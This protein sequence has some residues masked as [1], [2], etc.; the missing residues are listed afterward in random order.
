MEDTHK[1]DNATIEVMDSLL[2]TGE[3]AKLCGVTPDAVLKWIKKGKLPATRT[4]GGHYRVSREDCAAL[5]LIDSNG[6]QPATASSGRPDKERVPQR[7]WEYFGQRGAPP[8]TCRNC[9]V[10]Q[11]RVQYCYKLAELGEST[12][13]R[14]DFCR[15]NCLECPFYRACQGMATTVLVVTRD[16]GLT[17]RLGKQADASKVT[18]R[19][20]RSGYESATLIGTFR[21]AVV[22]MDSDLAEVRE[23]GLLESIVRDDRIPGV[24]V[25][26]AH[27]QGDEEAVRKLGVPTLT[28][29]FTAEQIE[30]LGESVA[31]GGRRASGDAT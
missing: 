25:F 10:Y 22:V 26:V 14:H 7:C 15:N 3:V 19:F 1:T 16:D 6:D 18:L 29:P 5:G 27:R 28:A 31:H 4:A 17:R 30:Q 9:L 11:A 8:E 13:H 23:G 2:S 20:A 24:R 21:P 12:G